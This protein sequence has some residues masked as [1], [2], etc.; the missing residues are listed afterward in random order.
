MD[1]TRYY[2]EVKRASDLVDGK[3]YHGAL[4]IFQSLLDSDISDLDKALMCHNIAVV[5]DKLG[6]RETALAW[7]DHGIAY[8]TPYMRFTAAEYKAAQLNQYGRTAEA[9]AI[10]ESLLP[11]PYLIEA[12]KERIWNNLTIL[13]NPRR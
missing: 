11:Q 1:Y 3:D 13:R 6:D 12:D 8:E 2:E 9:I 10:Y 4:A 7:Y 5:C